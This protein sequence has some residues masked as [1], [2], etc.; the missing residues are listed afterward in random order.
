MNGNG[1]IPMPHEM[2]LEQLRMDDPIYAFNRR[3]PPLPAPKEKLKFGVED[4]GNY[5]TPQSKR[6]YLWEAEE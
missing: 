4:E 6:K 1:W 2:V 3:N 5:G